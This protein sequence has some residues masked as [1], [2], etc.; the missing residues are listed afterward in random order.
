M[1]KH[2]LTLTLL[3]IMLLNLPAQKV[4]DALYLRNGSII[5]GKLMEISD[6]QYRIETSD[7]S[8]FVFKADEVEKFVKEVPGFESR[9][10][11]GYG[12]SLEAGLLAGSQSTSY[13][14]PF[15]FSFTGSYTA[16]TS[17]IFA[18]GSGV[19]FLGV[20][21]TPVFFEYKHLMRETR[22]TPFIFLRT[23]G[24]L[25]LGSDKD[26]YEPYQYEKR[27]Y[28]GGFSLTAGTGVS[29]GKDGFEPYISFAYRYAKTS[30][31]QYSY[32]NQ[33]AKF[34]NIFN[35]LEIKFGITF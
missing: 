22:V 5:Y 19:E 21:F 20:P 13:S 16:N 12:F 11:T 24:L 31:R 30:Y 9:K 23:G 34:E 32:N 8:K 28:K 27:D 3:T 4:K 25:H 29:W 18:L 1:K 15:S 33:D 10:V 35:R 7:G 17:N 2:L 6:N 26:T 14:A